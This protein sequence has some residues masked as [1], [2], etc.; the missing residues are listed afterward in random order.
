MPI[1]SIMTENIDYVEGCKVSE[2]AKGHMKH[3][4]INGKEIA[5]ANVTENSTLFPID[6]AI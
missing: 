4:A 6:A 3:V 1:Q 2:I 5:I